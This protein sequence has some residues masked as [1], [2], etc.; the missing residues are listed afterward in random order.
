MKTRNTQD[1]YCCHG[2]VQWGEQE[3]SPLTSDVL[4]EGQPMLMFSDKVLLGG[5]RGQLYFCVTND[6]VSH[7]FRCKD[8]TVIGKLEAG[9]R[10]YLFYCRLLSIWVFTFR[11]LNRECQVTWCFKT[12][13]Y[14][15]L[16]RKV[17]IVFC[18][19]ISFSSCLYC[20]IN[21]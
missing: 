1:K 20:K 19:H 17:C 18:F 6:L 12:Y 3:L 9:R 7:I 4:E 8:A 2:D 11:S 5:K 10:R 14:D 16:E 15:Y 13:F 21:L